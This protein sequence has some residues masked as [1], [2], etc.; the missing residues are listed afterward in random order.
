MFI[1]SGVLA[2]TIPAA[3]INESPVTKGTKAPIN[4]PVPAKTKPQTT[5]TNSTGPNWAYQ[6]A[7]SVAKD[8]YQA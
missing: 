6:D 1:T 5:A 7:N 4:N 2:A 8:M 3:K